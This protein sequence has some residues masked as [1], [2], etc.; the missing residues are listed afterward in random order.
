[1]PDG[2]I[3]SLDNDKN[4]VARKFADTMI[5]DAVERAEAR[6]NPPCSDWPRVTGTT[7]YKLVRSILFGSS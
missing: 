6:D 2:I 5:S 4:I 1:M 7:M 3:R